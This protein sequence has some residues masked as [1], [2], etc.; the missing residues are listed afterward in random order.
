MRVDIDPRL[1]TSDDYNGLR[2]RLYDIFKTLG[3]QINGL[4]EGRMSAKHMAL[5]A[6]P[7]TGTWAK[8]DVVTNSNPSEAGAAASK[9]VITHWV[10]TVSGT[11]GTWVQCR[12]LTGN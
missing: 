9:Y 12:T 5:T 10:C 4:S 2:T 7:T 11:P 6:A 8:G 1:P 3:V